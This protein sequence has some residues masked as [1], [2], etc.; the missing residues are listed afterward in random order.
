M[1]KIRI[2]Y[3]ATHPIQYQAPLFKEISKS[4]CID[5]KVLFFSDFSSKSYN[6]V[7]FGKNIKWDIPLFDGYKYKYLSCNDSV[8]K[9]TFYSPIIYGLKDEL[10]TGGYDA[11]LIQ[12]WNHYGYIQALWLAKKYGLK[13]LLRCEATDDVDG[14]TGAKRFFRK[15]IVKYILNNADKMLAIGSNNRNFYLSRGVDKN[16]IGS[17]PYCVDNT[18]FKD[19]SDSADITSLKSNLK[20]YDDKPILLYA[21]KLTKRKYADHLVEAYQNLPEP[22]PYLLIVGDGEL[23]EKLEEKQQQALLDDVKIIGFVNQSQ[24]VS[25]YKL[26]DIFVL[27]SVNE[28]WRLVVNEAMN[29]GCAII[30]SDRVGSGVDLV[31]PGINGDIFNAKNVDS[32]TRSLRAC[33]DNK[34][35]IQMGKNS[36]DIISNWGIKENVMGLE[37]ALGCDINTK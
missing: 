16:K 2:A 5:L 8:N 21:S 29:A 18:F 36:I 35:Y 4:P 34:K 24:L 12:G 26:A 19:K 33:L 6:D 23:K 27:P 11:I 20:I 15:I 31:K 37:K 13:V 30:V 7:E 17:M 32:L 9:V 28:T 3:L 1:K 25:F 14:S 10:S 22:K